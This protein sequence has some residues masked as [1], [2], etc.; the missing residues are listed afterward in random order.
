LRLTDAGVDALR[1]REQLIAVSG[2]LQLRVLGREMSM[3]FAAARV[4]WVRQ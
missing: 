1:G 2:E 3:P 4:G